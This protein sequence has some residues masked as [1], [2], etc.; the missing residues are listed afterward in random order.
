MM[1]QKLTQGKHLHGDFSRRIVTSHL[2]RAID[3]ERKGELVSMPRVPY[4]SLSAGAAPFT[5]FAQRASKCVIRG[6]V[7]DCRAA[8]VHA[9]V[10][11]DEEKYVPR[12]SR[13]AL[14][15]SP[16]ER[17]KK[18][19]SEVS[20][21]YGWLVRRAVPD[22]STAAERRGKK[23]SSCHLP[24]DGLVTP[25][26]VVSVQSAAKRCRNIDMGKQGLGNAVICTHIRRLSMDR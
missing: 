1:F 3:E 25:A 26:C 9:F 18:Q 15:D 20:K 23:K 24:C 6:M 13:C 19:K 17:G 4:G 8:S 12:C 11:C 21:E 5:S 16:C 22:F 10:L 14:Y 7:D 2:E